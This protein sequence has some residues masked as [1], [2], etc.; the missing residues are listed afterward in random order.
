[1]LYKVTGIHRAFHLQNIQGE[2]WTWSTRNPEAPLDTNRPAPDNEDQSPATNPWGWPVQKIHFHS[3]S[4]MGGRVVRV[5]GCSCFMHCVD[6]SHHLEQK[7]IPCHSINA[8]NLPQ[9]FKGTSNKAHWNTMVRDVFAPINI[10]F[11][12]SERKLGNIYRPCWPPMPAP[13]KQRAA[14]RR[15]R[16]ILMST[17]TCEGFEMPSLLLDKASWIMMPSLPYC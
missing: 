11:I 14:T 15:G 2:H 3:L 12:C 7:H 6:D 8:I 4:Y 1:M 13:L 10:Y 16:V 9:L 17:P 5:A